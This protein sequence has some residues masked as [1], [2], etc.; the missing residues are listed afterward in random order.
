MTGFV[1][2][3][4]VVFVLLLTGLCVLLVVRMP[5]PLETPDRPPFPHRTRHYR[6]AGIA[7]PAN[8][9]ATQKP[10]EFAEKA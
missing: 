6:H 8:A 3:F 10:G 4:V 1:L 5:G 7:P 9:G 2:I